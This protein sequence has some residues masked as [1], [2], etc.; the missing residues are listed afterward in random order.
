MTITD[1]ARRL[2]HRHRYQLTD[3]G[4]ILATLA[5]V[6]IAGVL[7]PLAL[8][9]SLAHRPSTLAANTRIT[10]CPGWG[11]PYGAP[12]LGS[13]ARITRLPTDF[14]QPSEAVP[15]RSARRHRSAAGNLITLCE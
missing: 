10:D 2:L 3:I 8:R 5:F 13:S 6:V 9:A 7:A 12:G 11:I 1:R 4:L 14:A 15:N